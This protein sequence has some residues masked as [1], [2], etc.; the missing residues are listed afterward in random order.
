MTRVNLPPGCLGFKADDGTRYVAK[1]GTFVEVEDRHMPALKN[2][3]YASAGLVDA[4]PEKHFI[5]SGP[6]GRWCASCP[7]NT[8]YHAWK[9]I[10]PRCGAETLP[11]SGMERIKLP[12][13]YMP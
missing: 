3:Q 6:E 2:Q 11:E 9:T 4:G 7:S 10:C 12:G 13:H 8:I 5:R 1:P